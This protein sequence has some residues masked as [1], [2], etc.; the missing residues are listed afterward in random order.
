MLQVGRSDVQMPSRVGIAPTEAAL[1]GKT[2]TC[3]C[4]LCT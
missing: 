4:K 2:C 1:S 3:T